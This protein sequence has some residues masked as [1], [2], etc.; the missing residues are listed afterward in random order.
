VYEPQGRGDLQ[1][2]EVQHEPVLVG[3]RGGE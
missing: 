1:R 3:H 2:Q